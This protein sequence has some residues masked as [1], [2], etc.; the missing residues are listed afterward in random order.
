MQNWTEA[1]GKRRG[2]VMS[3]VER[4]R[5]VRGPEVDRTYMADNKALMGFSTVDLEKVRADLA[6]AKRGS[7]GG[8]RNGPPSDAAG[9]D[10][11]E[12][13]VIN[14]VSTPAS[15]AVGHRADPCPDGRTLGGR[16]LAFGRPS[17]RV[18]RH[19]S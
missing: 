8:S 5:A 9:M 6:L 14:A 7:V 11:V 13:E 1:L 2:Y 3:V 19:A 12:L 15:V 16:I 17:A 10:E 4:I 18:G